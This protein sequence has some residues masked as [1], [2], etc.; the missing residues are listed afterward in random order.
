[1]IHDGLSNT[2]SGNLKGL[3]IFYRRSYSR[4]ILAK[5]FLYRNLMEDDLTFGVSVWGTPDE[6]LH[7]ASSSS[8]PLQLPVTLRN[9]D[10]D[11]ED[12]GDPVTTTLE[13][14]DD[15]GDFGNAE[16]TFNV[17]D[18]D[19]STAFGEEVRIPAP[20]DAP[21]EPLR[22]D[23]MPS[24]EE[25]EQQINHILGP[26]W[27][28][29]VVSR[30]TTDEDIRQAEGINQILI[31]QDRSVSAHFIDTLALNNQYASRDL[32]NSLF[33][34]QPPLKPPNWT[35]SR[36]RRQHLIALGIPVNLDEVLPHANGKPLPPLQITTRPTST[37][38]GHRN[39]NNN[40]LTGASQSRAGTPQPTNR[41]AGQSNAAQLGLG[42]KPE[43]DEGKIT[44][45]LSLDAGLCFQ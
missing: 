4:R 15:F 29:E 23:P 32:Y 5:P 44:G 20:S 28:D 41:R 35:Q 43:L 33:Q 13:E 14:D 7:Q 27:G 34:S 21:W 25:L 18:F 38:P 2:N 17:A 22:L 16:E 31:S 6:P 36:I 37:P 24:R 39:P 19:G 45:L 3:H 42:P 26:I 9:T 1:M 11:F 8:A 10:D 40:A 12:F 30:L